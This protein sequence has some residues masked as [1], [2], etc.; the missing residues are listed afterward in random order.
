[1]SGLTLRHFERR[2]I[3]LPVELVVS[4]AHRE[5]VRFSAAS[6]ST[7][8]HSIQ[9][10][11]IDVSSGGFG[12]RTRQFVPRTCEASLRVL[13]PNPTGR[14]SDGTPVFN[15]VFEHAVKVRRV[16]MTSHEPSYFIGVSFVDP[17]PGLDVKIIRLIESAKAPV[18]AA[19]AARHA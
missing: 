10:R 11:T 14:N 18:G 9:A 19:R 12:L 16:S 13:D 2:E 1:M 3:D 17:E 5:Q 6:A 7:G 15:V 4:E 8:P